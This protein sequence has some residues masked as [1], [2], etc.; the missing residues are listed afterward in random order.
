MSVHLTQAPDNTMEKQ[1]ST[2]NEFD[3]VSTPINKGVTLLEASAGTGKTYALAMLV[4]RLVVEEGLLLEKILVVTFTKA[5]TEEL[6]TRIRSRLATAQKALTR[7]EGTAELD[8]KLTKWLIQVQLT[9]P[10][11]E[12]Q[13]R[14]NLALLDIDRA[15]IFTIHGFCQRVLREHALESGQLFNVELSASIDAI[16]Q[17]CADDFWRKQMYERS[18]WEVALLRS[19]FKTPDALLASVKNFPAAALSAHTHLH[20]SPT[21][22]EHYDVDKQLFLISELAKNVR[23]EFDSCSERI[24]THKGFFK[25]IYIKEFT[26]YAPILHAWIEG[27]NELPPPATAFALFTTNTIKEGLHGTKFK[28]TKK[29]HGD[30]RKQEFL[31]KLD[32]KNQALT[33]LSTA[34]HA[35]AL[36]FRCAL[37]ETLRI[38]LTQRGQELNV[39]SFDDLIIRLAEALQSEKAD[40]LTQALR[41]RFSVALIDEFQDTDDE[42]WF[43]FSTLFNCDTHALFLIG[44]PKQAIYKFRGADIYSYLAAQ[45]TAQQRYTL[46]ENWRSHPDLVTAV[47]TLFK[48]ENVF[49]LADLVFKPVRPAKSAT[50]AYLSLAGEPI[51]PLQ[52]WQLNQYSADTSYWSSTKADAQLQ[53]AVVKEIVRLLTK[54]VTLQPANNRLQPN[55]I[56]ILVK[57]NNQAKAY[58]QALL[59][60]GVPAL[61]NGTESVF[62]S[63]EAEALL[64]L[65]RAIAKPNDLGLLRQAL[66]CA[67]YGMDG[68]ALFQLFGNQEAMDSY[69]LQFADYHQYWQQ[70]GALAMIIKVLSHSKIIAYLPKCP[71]AERVMTNIYHLIELLQQAVHEEY[72]GL[73]KTLQWLESRIIEAKTTKDCD[74]HH[75]LRLES[76]ANAVQIITMHRAKGLEYPV[77]FCPYLWSN[78]KKNDTATI[79]SCHQDNHQLIDI[80]STDFAQHQ[81]MAAQESRAEAIRVAYVALTRAKYL[82][83]VIWADVH[84]KETVNQSA[85][86]RLINLSDLSFDEQFDTLRALASTTGIAHTLI[87]IP[88]VA[89]ERYQHPI[90]TTQTLTALTRQRLWYT[91]WQMSSY[92]ALAN[93]R[94]YDAAEFANDSS[95]DDDDLTNAPQDNT[96]TVNQHTSP[97]ENIPKGA[98]LGNVVHRLLESHRYADLA[99]ANINNEQYQQLCQQY[100]VEFV[101]PELLAKCLQ[102]LVHT[103]L[104]AT[105]PSFCLKNIEETK[106]LK[107]LAFYVS[108]PKLDVAQ[109]NAALAFSPVYQAL[110]SKLL[111]GYLTGFI[112]LVCEYQGQY[113]VMDY[114]T[115]TL[116]DYT[117]QRLQQAMRHHNYGLQYWLYTVVL[118]RY[119][120]QRLDGYDYEMHFG[121]V[122]YLFV[123]GMSADQPLSGVYQDRPAREKVEEL[124][125]LFT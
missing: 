120:Q 69:L 104:S 68:Q 2:V 95:D 47:N 13:R 74:E 52:L 70:Q 3:V 119:L 89:T 44:D 63:P 32:L 99:L 65:L 48:R 82:N 9:L 17:A 4:L 40:N 77:V 54:E 118:H 59:N 110:P 57:S 100:G 43:I 114:K 1:D 19:H 36:T 12:I 112:D 33:E 97:W 58:Q 61:I 25:D 22:Q 72:L 85:L 20:V 66:S 123:R 111:S 56:A 91:T 37:L 116:P 60:A 8:E 86:A 83:Y 50:E 29:I 103:P 5:A 21:L 26:D 27:E 6:K 31:E 98:Q 41:T 115:N 24:K 93:T 49:C 108:L 28:T 42:Q 125:A 121:G 78:D 55:D 88:V 15:A 51:V 92:T 101:A 11:T 71:S 124:A 38:E 46:G 102:N 64:T 94:T 73:N 90:N 18:V 39:L 53:Q 14:L 7:A 30:Q 45:K 16:K 122:R 107:E 35:L 76:D 10:K 34:I 81:K 87:D 117:E 109:I 79:V 96:P 67:W 62:T 106:C 75:V 80:G 105:E 113:Y 23:E 84:N